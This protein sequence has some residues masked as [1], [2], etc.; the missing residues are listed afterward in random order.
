MAKLTSRIGLGRYEADQHY[1]AALQSY[2]DRRPR[3][4]I[5][6]MDYALMILPDHPEYLAARG[7]FHLEAGQLEQA[8]RDTDAA[9][10]INPFEVLANY[11]KGVLHFQRREWPEAQQAFMKAWA[12]DTQRAETQYYL[13]LVAYRMGDTESARRWMQ[14]ARALLEALHDKARLADADAWLR[15]FDLLGS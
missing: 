7:F 9:L 3:D 15:E 1:H 4:A 2:R 10:R 11:N 14:R 8:E 5:Q 12:A 13:A 6:N